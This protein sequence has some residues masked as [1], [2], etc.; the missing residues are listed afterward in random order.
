[1]VTRSTSNSSDASNSGSLSNTTKGLGF[2]SVFSFPGTRERE[3]IQ[4]LA[5]SGWLYMQQLLTVGK[6]DQETIPPPELLCQIL[7]ELGPVYVKLGQL[8]STRPDLLSPAYVTALSR[9]QS[10]VP[11]VNWTQMERQI[12]QYLPQSPSEIFAE[13]DPQP[14]AAGSIAQTHKAVLKNGQPVVLKVQRPGI[15]QVVAS[16]MAVLQQLADRLSGTDFGRRYGVASLVEEFNLA[17]TNELDFTQEA[18]Y[19]DQLRHN[20]AKATWFDPKKICIPTIFS[21]YSSSQV[22]VMEY[23]D[24]VPILHAEL[25]G[26][27]YGGSVKAERDAI[28]SLVFRS[29]IQQY[30]VDG[31]FHADPHPGNLFYLKDGRVAVL[32]C[33]MM[34]SM[35]P[36]L[37][38]LLVELMLA[39]VEVDSERCT[40]LTTQITSPLDPSVPINLK[41]LQEDYDRLLRRYYN[42]RLENVDMGEALNAVLQA[43]RRNN[44]AFPSNIGL[45]SKSVTNLEGTGLLFNPDLNLL[46]E[47]KPLL[48]DMIWQ[49]LRG[50]NMALLRSALELKG[51]SLESP[52]QFGFLLSRL[53]S[54]TLQVNMMLQGLDGLRRTID[55]AASRLSFSLILGS[56]IMGAAFISSGQQTPQLQLLT[57]IFFAVASILGLWVVVSTLRSGGM[58]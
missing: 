6:A 46:A 21:D 7:V 28:T 32:D 55:D 45:L 49:Q 12:R 17:L 51:L 27:G 50:S 36:R 37:K 33:G 48:P 13:I 20:L 15:E 2:P 41:Q 26:Q 24:G 31:F 18:I 30:L 19:T 25:T 8:L 47:M 44:L 38:S 53:S 1:M 10:E 34:G 58:R 22:L 56:L 5:R 43:A 3:I 39:I 29:F 42:L 57:N 4:V 9:L 23:L 35:D 16:D 14:L 40:Q 52:R 11:P 54:Q